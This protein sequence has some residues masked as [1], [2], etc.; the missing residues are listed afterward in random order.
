MFFIGIE[1][2]K[3]IYYKSNENIIDKR[4][5]CVQIFIP[6]KSTCVREVLLKQGVKYFVIVNH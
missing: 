6:W 3:K 4:S 2:L 5:D 1:K